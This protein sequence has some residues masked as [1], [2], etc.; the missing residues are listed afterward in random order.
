MKKFLLLMCLTQV[1]CTESQ[2][3]FQSMQIF[4][5]GTRYAVVSSGDD[6]RFR[7][8]YTKGYQYI[9]D[10]KTVLAECEFQAKKVADKITKDM[11][12]QN[13]SLLELSRRPIRNMLSGETSCEAEYVIK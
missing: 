3:T 1:A 4:E 11:G 7:V 13:F 9:P 12:I 6:V 8:F 10:R 5:I 2:S